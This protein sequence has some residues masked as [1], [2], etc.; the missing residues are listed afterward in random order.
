[1]KN[2][3]RAAFSVISRRFSP[4]LKAYNG[5][6]RRGLRE[7]KTGHCPAAE[8]EKG[9]GSAEMAGAGLFAV[10]RADGR[11]IRP[12]RPGRRDGGRDPAAGSGCRDG[13]GRRGIFVYGFPI[14][15]NW[16]VAPLVYPTN[17]LKIIKNR[18]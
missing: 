1:M 11:G 13:R 4:G 2:F 8:N 9:G 15:K 7:K 3:R 12:L 5:E 18:I 16:S 6:K 10:C 17:E 14:G